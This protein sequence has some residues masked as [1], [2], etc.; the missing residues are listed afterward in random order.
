LVIIDK[1]K[2][3]KFAITIIINL[4]NFL[5]FYKFNYLADT[6]QKLRRLSQQINKRASLNYETLLFAV[7]HTSIINFVQPVCFV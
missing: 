2:P 6:G 5:N 4:I 3:G 7:I 1:I